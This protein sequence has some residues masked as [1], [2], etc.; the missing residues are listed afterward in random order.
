MTTDL[1]TPR[2]PKREPASPAASST[3]GCTGSPRSTMPMEET[4]AAANADARAVVTDALVAML[5]FL[6][7][8]FGHRGGG[9]AE[10]HHVERAGGRPVVVERIGARDV[11]VDQAAQR[12]R[13]R[14]E[15]AR[16]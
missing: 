15:L 4:S 2:G 8:L 7:G 14:A 11:G 10:P 6:R 9:D 1:P 13:Q 12:Q 5:R 16:Q 3:P